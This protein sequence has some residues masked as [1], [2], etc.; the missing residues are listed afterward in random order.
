VLEIGRR[1][2]G[3]AWHRVAPIQLRLWH[4]EDQTA[5]LLL[6]GVHFGVTG[7]LWIRRGK[8]ATGRA[9]VKPVVMARVGPRLMCMGATDPSSNTDQGV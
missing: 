3:C 6:N 4:V 8:M 1:K 7:Q 2:P 9:S 5:L